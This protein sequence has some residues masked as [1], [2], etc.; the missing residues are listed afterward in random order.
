MKNLHA[1]VIGA[2]GATGRLLVELLLKEKDFNQVTIFVRN[3]P[4]FNNEKLTIHK[5]DFAKLE[6]YKDLIR[7]Y[8]FFSFRNY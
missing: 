4:T 6:E 5:I 7:R 2:T 8:S 3:A 1:L